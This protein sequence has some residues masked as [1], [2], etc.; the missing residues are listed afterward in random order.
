MAK[1]LEVK[2][3][4]EAYEDEMRLQRADGEY[5]WFLIR[6]AP[7]L[8]EQGNLLKRYGVAIDIEERKRAEEEIHRHA[9]RMEARA[10]I[11][12]ALAK[13][14]LD[15]RT[16]L[17][18]IARY[19]AEVIGDK[20]V[21]RLLSSDEKRFNLAAFHHPKPETLAL[22]KSLYPGTPI[23]ASHKWAGH[24]LQTRQPLL[25]P[26][27]NQEQL[28]EITQPEY[29]PFVEQVGMHSILVLPL[30]VDGRVIGSL[31]LSRDHPEHPYTSDD[32]V[33]LQ[34][35]AD[36]AALTI[37]NAQLFEQVQN[38][39]QRL[40]SLSRSLLEVQENERRH[41][42]RE[43]HDEIGQVLT[44]IKLSLERSAREPPD[45][46]KSSVSQALGLVTELVGRVRDLSLELRP[47]MLDD[48]GL[49]SALTWQ[50]GRYTSQFEIR[51]NFKHSRLDEQRFAPD[52]ETAAYRIVQEA[53]TNVARHAGVGKVD[54]DI[55]ADESRIRIRIRDEGVGFDAH[56]LSACSTGG[57]SGM[58]ERASMLGGQLD[59]ESA[60][61]AGTLLR[62]EL[63]LR[64][65]VDN[66]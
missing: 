49:L 30:C 32:Q 46:V 66:H 19:T 45:C 63:P 7:L 3:T 23:A 44:G 61:G 5:R 57:L 22:M 65:T 35:L 16:V 1:W 15:V 21:I 2:A 26:I 29:L 47:P 13:V 58:R 64:M 11:S 27:V 12:Q 37:Q 40:Q 31:A 42:A 43:L 33:F 9:A 18:T 62:A 20:C 55:Q 48:L 8:D 56:T 60:P 51:V 24:V 59:V 10:E 50:F 54:V 36:R 6:I 53:L 41:I 17:D 52:I 4:S 25:I 39:H 38:A 34:D 28:R 14:G